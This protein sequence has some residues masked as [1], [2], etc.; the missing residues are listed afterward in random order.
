MA[1]KP[2]TA[3]LDIIEASGALDRSRTCMVGDRLDTDIAFGNAGKLGSTLLVLTGVTSAADAAAVPPGD[4][5]RPS[6]VLG[7]F[8]ELHAVVLAARR[9]LASAGA[10]VGMR[11]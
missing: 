9:A 1:G 8:G 7:S 4:A 2:S 6:H 5:R 11:G 3:L 10:G